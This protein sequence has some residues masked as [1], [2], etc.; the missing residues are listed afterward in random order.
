MSGCPPWR[1]DQ[2]RA[3]PKVGVLTPR[4]GTLSFMVLTN[5]LSDRLF[6]LKRPRRLTRACQKLG[7]TN[8]L[9][10]LWSWYEPRNFGDWIGPYLFWKITGKRPLFCRPARIGGRIPNRATT[11]ASAGSILR[12]IVVPDKVRVWGSGIISMNDTFQRPLKIHAVRGPRSMKRVRELG[13][14]CPEVFGDP[15]ILLPKVYTPMIEKRYTLG[16]IPHYSDFNQVALSLKTRRD[17]HVIDVTRDVESVVDQ[18]LS[19]EATLSSSLHGLILSHTYGVPCAWIASENQLIGDNVKFLD[20]L[21]SAGLYEITTSLQV[22]LHQSSAELR[23]L[24]HEQ[25][26]PYLEPLTENLLYSCPFE[27]SK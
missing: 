11:V 1:P 9:N 15:A 17:L 16:I 27:V 3:F 2:I 20:Y 14:E 8:H 12:H 19:C 6:I 18:I 26:K 4:R 21:E 22:D 7:L 25:P 13:Y 23:A 24:A 10:V 5:K